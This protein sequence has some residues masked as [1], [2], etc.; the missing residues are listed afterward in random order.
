MGAS[1]PFLWK[2][3]MKKTIVILAAL[4]FQLFGFN[5]LA[6]DQCVAAPQA[7]GATYVIA[8]SDIAQL[9]PVKHSSFKLWRKGSNVLH[10]YPEKEISTKWHQLSNGYAR[11][12][13]HFEHYQRSIEFEP[14]RLA[15]DAWNN[16][17]QL[18]SDQL[19]AQMTLLV[20]QGE[21]CEQ[22]NHYQFS[23]KGISIELWWQPSIKLAH[24]IIYKENQVLT[25]WTLSDLSLANKDIEKALMQAKHYQTTDYADIGDNESDPFLR[26]M[27]HLGF[28][29][30]GH[31]GF[32]DDKGNQLLNK[33][34]H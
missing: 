29:E 15:N 7:L 20:S 30:S 2:V 5:S 14:T 32:Y 18:I 3:K 22:I 34:H 16:K 33:H 28:V 9:S 25:T 13:S 4:G 12:V 31:G 17:Y 24:K 27:I 19:I 23:G 21:D 26:K 6:Q 11:K 8:K 10:I 1:A